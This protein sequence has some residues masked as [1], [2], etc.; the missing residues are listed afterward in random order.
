[1][2]T[3]NVTMPSGLVINDVPVNY[4]KSELVDKLLSNGYTLDELGLTD[5]PSHEAKLKAE[6][7]RDE[8]MEN[9]SFGDVL[10]AVKSGNWS[11][12]GDKAK[13]Q[14][15]VITG[16]DNNNE[17]QQQMHNKF[18]TLVKTEASIPLFMTGAELVES[19]PAVAEMGEGA[20]LGARAAK[21]FAANAAGSAAA[22]LG[23][24]G[25]I[26]THQLGVDTL[27][28]GLIEGVGN[29]LITPAAKQ[30]LKLFQKINVASLADYAAPEVSEYMAASRTF[31]MAKDY[32]RIKAKNP[33]ATLF[34]AYQSL[35]EQSPA[36]YDTGSIEDIKK[37]TRSLKHNIDPDE[38][39][40]HALDIKMEKAEALK[41]ANAKI[42]DK[43]KL[44]RT[45]ENN[46]NYKGNLLTGRMKLDNDLVEATPFQRIGEALGD[47]AGFGNEAS[48]F[49]K[50]N[51]ATNAVKDDAEAL[52]KKL[53][54]DNKRLTAS[55]EKLRNSGQQG[56]HIT[57]HKTALRLQK[58][59]NDRMIKF[60]E[61]GLKGN[62]VNV[63]DFALTIKEAEEQ[64]FGNENF[65]KAFRDLAE[66]Y[67]QL[68]LIKL[69]GNT[70]ELEKAAK[71][72]AKWGLKKTGLGAGVLA[73]PVLGGALSVGA[74]VL[75]RT[76]QRFKSKALEDAYLLLE[77][78]KNGKVT[79]DEAEKVLKERFNDRQKAVKVLRS[80]SGNNES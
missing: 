20:S 56:A 71:Q 34:D 8:D 75:G 35:Y 65:T 18:K 80:A 60:L 16:N 49:F 52:I 62:K 40:D 50:G 69:E 9:I 58:Q 32:A 48:A 2:N 47:W 15:D 67:D 7:A 5:S 13:Y 57:S 31:D 70:G 61:S 78:V 22:Q 10:N 14:W 55:Q 4:S 6:H 37:F 45:A 38:F 63:N 43:G 29:K 59:T 53:E 23:T 27:T 41:A 44:I 79:S 19:I 30:A 33:N 11:N 68:N 26:N 73:N 21:T 64:E 42:A 3:H 28:G 51:A 24:E 46:H 36:I 66:R 54:A 74:T 72:L 12:V 17:V 1:M 25:R 39:L 77:D 76:A